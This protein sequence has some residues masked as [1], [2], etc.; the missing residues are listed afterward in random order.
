MYTRRVKEPMGSVS[1][2]LSTLN[3]FHMVVGHICPSPLDKCLTSD[4]M[5]GKL[6]FERETFN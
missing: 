2:S 4:K 5:H 3:L 6:N 1:T